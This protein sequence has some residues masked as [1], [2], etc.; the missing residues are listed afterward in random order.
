MKLKCDA[1]RGLEPSSL[2]FRAVLD[3]LRRLEEKQSAQRRQAWAQKEQERVA[4]PRDR[5]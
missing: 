4:A 1:R 2:G 3:G 5:V